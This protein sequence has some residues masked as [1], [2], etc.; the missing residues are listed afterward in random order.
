M[1]KIIGICSYS[2][3]VDTRLSCKYHDELTEVSDSDKST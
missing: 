3:L 2:S 1:E